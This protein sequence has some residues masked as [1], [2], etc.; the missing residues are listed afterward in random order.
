[1]RDPLH[2]A[3]R[4][5]LVGRPARPYLRPTVLGERGK[6]RESRDRRGRV[7]HLI[8][9]WVLGSG[10]GPGRQALL[11]RRRF[12]LPP[13]TS[14]QRRASAT[15]PTRLET[16]TEESWPFASRRGPLQTPEA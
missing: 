3:S 7:A 10:L 15:H 14:G 9:P 11:R 12:T 2:V 5:F 13:A 8:G 4:S 1:M 6:E 16:R